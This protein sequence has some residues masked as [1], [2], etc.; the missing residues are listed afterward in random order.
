MIASDT[1]LNA[2]EA[3]FGGVKRPDDEALIRDPLDLDEAY[4]LNIFRMRRS[5]EIDDL[6]K[7]GVSSAEDLYHLSPEGVHYFLP[8]Y[9]RYVVRNYSHWEYCIVVGL[10]QFLDVERRL[11]YGAIYPDFTIEQKTCVKLVLLFMDENL[12]RYDVEDEKGSVRKCLQQVIASP[13]WN[14]GVACPASAGMKI[15]N[16]RDKKQSWPWKFFLCVFFLAVAMYANLFSSFLTCMKSPIVTGKT[17]GLLME[18]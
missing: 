8:C 6:T 17:I 2:I 11:S 9:L 15:E 1:V 14:G 4:A 10:I 16:K 18:S 12:E 7:I 3:A 5:E 13:F